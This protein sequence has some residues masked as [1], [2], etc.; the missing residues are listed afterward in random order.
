MDETRKFLDSLKQNGES[1]SQTQQTQE[2]VE[3]APETTEEETEEEKPQNRRER[4]LRERLQS[5]REA[6]IALAA[7]L[8]AITSAQELR[9]QPDR[10]MEAIERLYGTETPEAREAT[11]I[12]KTVLSSVKEEA[13]SEALRELRIER[14]RERQ[15]VAQAESQ[16]ERHIE[17]LEDEY[18]VDITG[19]ERTGFLKMLEK[20]SPKDEDGNIT[21]YADPKAVWEVYQSSKKRDNTQAKSVA[22][23]SLATSTKSGSNVS[24]D[25]YAQFIRDNDLYF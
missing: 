4:R 20:M 12:L 14:E 21:H 9:Q 23:R 24:D 5:E 22:S 2:T 11:S 15:E 13:K 1:F 6:A 19:Q 8:E 16:L 17:S 10:H 18:R 3:E 7:K 25:V